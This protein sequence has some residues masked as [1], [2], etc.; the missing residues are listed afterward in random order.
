MS[1]CSD[2]ILQKIYKH[3][4]FIACNNNWKKNNINLGGKK[5]PCH[6][7]SQDETVIPAGYD[8]DII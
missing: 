5:Q 7:Q 3:M 6:C 2:S 4:Q 1:S 8:E